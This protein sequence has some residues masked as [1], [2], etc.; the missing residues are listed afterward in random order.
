VVSSAMAA[1]YV[2]SIQSANAKW[3]GKW[4]GSFVRFV[5]VNY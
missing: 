1:V 5:A 2:A 3:K 4:K